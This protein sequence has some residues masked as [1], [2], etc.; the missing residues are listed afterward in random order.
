MRWRAWSQKSSPRPPA[1]G[2]Q[3]P[4]FPMLNSKV[5]SV[6]RMLSCIPT[7]PAFSRY[8]LVRS[9]LACY[10][11]V[12]TG[13]QMSSVRKSSQ[14]IHG[15]AG[16][17]QGSSGRWVVRTH[18]SFPVTSVNHH[19]NPRSPSSQISL[20]LDPCI[21]IACQQCACVSATPYF[22]LALDV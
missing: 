16:H 10:A 14:A 1:L 12:A 22:Q 11:I 2:Y 21:F 7:T 9:C 4:F 8:H 17:L 13:L 19:K 5:N 20:F 18:V 6:R 3:E 15:N